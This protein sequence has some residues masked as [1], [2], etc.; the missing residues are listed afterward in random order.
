MVNCPY[1]KNQVLSK[2]ALYIC[3]GE[4]VSKY[5]ETDKGYLILWQVTSG[6]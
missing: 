6:C 4:L 3:W 2:S 1:I 5:L